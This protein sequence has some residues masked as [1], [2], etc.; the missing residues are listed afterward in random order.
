MNRLRL[1][2]EACRAGSPRLRVDP[3]VQSERKGFYLLAGLTHP[4][5][6]RSGKTSDARS[7][8]QG[9]APHSRRPNP[10]ERYYG[11]LRPTQGTSGTPARWLARRAQTKNRSLSR[12]R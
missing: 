6:E 7:S 1:P 12:F 5:E 11:F 8:G 9:G 2:G 4:T 3:R 10:R